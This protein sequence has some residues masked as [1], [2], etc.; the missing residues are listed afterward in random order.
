MQCLLKRFLPFAL[1]MIFGLWLASYSSP[2]RARVG[3]IVYN[4]P[5]HTA[6]PVSIKSVPGIVYPA[7]SCRATNGFLVTI[8]LEALLGADG[9][10]SEIKPVLM[11]PYGVSEESLSPTERAE[12]SPFIL[13]GKF[14]ERLPYGLTEAA[15]EAFRQIE[16]IPATRDGQPIPVRVTIDTRFS[17]TPGIHSVCNS[18]GGNYADTV[19]IEG[20]A[21]RWRMMFDDR[22][23]RVTISNGWK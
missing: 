14:V 4:S 13:D 8:R 9:T 12:N 11:L 20:D 17:Y 23:F 19:I 1:T 15:I 18:F 16:F 7:A 22:R 2:P 21:V 5:R 6:V 10:V 3:K